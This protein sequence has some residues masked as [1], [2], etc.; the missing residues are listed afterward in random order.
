MHHLMAHGAWM[1]LPC[2]LAFVF[3]SPSKMGDHSKMYGFG[4][5]LGFLES[6]SILCNEPINLLIRPNSLNC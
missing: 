2:Y 3:K 1:N 6:N 4:S 5:I